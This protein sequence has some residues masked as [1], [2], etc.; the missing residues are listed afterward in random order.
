MSDFGEYRFVKTNKPHECITCERI[1][2]K[3]KKAYNYNGMYEG[4]WQNWYMCEPCEQLNVCEDNEEI[5]GEEF[6]MWLIESKHAEC[7]KCK[8][9]DEKG[10][11]HGYHSAYKWD[12]KKETLHFECEL[13]GHKWEKFIGFD[14]TKEAIE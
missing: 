9:I 1:I 12:E 2:P 6:H 13:C 8:G 3:G 14:S 7:P 5:C 4:D 10:T 11:R